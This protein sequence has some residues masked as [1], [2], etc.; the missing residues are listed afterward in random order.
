[1]AKFQKKLPMSA[2][3]RQGGEGVINPQDV[4]KGDV[5]DMGS[6]EAPRSPRDPVGPTQIGKGVKAPKPPSPPKLPAG[7]KT[8]KPP[9]MPKLGKFK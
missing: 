3:L 7:P 2:A 4:K 1:M 5:F 8:L 9:S 6:V